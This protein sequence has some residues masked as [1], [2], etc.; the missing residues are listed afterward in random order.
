VV[1]LVVSVAL[2]AGGIAVCLAVGRRRPPGHP[3]TWG[4]AFVASVFVFGL[5]LL[6]YGVVPNQ[7]LKFADDELL[8]R[9]DKILGKFALFGRGQVTVSYQAVRD[10][11][12]S[13]IYVLMLVFH[14]LLWA[15]WQKRGRKSAE[16]VPT[17]AYGRPLVKA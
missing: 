15:Q 17:S 16:V 11:L 12:V 8:W 9:S 13:G 14:V 5:M 1:A 6:A 7:W 3:F 4:E 10:I 2:L